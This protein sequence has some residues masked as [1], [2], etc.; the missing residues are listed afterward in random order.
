MKYIVRKSQPDDDVAIM[1]INR[2]E[3]LNALDKE[4]AAELYTAIEI[5]GADD[6]I[7]VIIIGAGENPFVQV[8]ILDTLQTS[9]LLKRK[10]MQLL[11]MVCL[12]K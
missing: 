10:D 7:K 6:N 4:V 1:K 3:V 9:I 5:A 11:C 2:P 8:E 12:T